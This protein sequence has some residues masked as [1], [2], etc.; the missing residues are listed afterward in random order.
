MAKIR[1]STQAVNR[2]KNKVRN[3]TSRLKPFTMEE[4]INKPKKIRA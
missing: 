4:R 3:I 2:Y 1:V